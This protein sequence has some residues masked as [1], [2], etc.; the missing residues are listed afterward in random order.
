MY[1]IKRFFHVEAATRSKREVR[2]WLR[3]HAGVGWWD[4]MRGRLCG[5]TVEYV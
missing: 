3:E 5:Y 1:F 4:W 2:R